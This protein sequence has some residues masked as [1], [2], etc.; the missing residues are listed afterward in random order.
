MAEENISDDELTALFGEDGEA[1][2]EAQEIIC[3][4]HFYIGGKFVLW[5]AFFMPFLAV[6]KFFLF[7]F[8][9]S[10]KIYNFYI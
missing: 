2:G 3:G 5:K 8:L 10:G 9:F 7:F 1:Q 6:C 4:K